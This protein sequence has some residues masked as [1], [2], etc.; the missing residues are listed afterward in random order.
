MTKV[1]FVVPCYNSATSI[2]NVVSEIK[3]TILKREGYD[4]EIILINDCSRDKTL[5][6]IENICKSN[7]KVKGINLTKNFGQHAALM[8]GYKVST[9]DIV[10]SMDDDG[11][12]PANEVFSLIDKLNEGYDVVYASYNTKRHGNFRNFGSK[13]NKIMAE[14]LINKPKELQVTSYF[15]ARR[16]IINEILKYRNAFPYVVGLIL[17]TT[18]NI[19]NTPVAHLERAEGNSNYNLSKLVSLWMNGFTAF[20]VKPLRIASAIGVLCALIG[21]F[22]TIYIIVYKILNP[23]LVAGYSSLMAALLFLG[24]I[25]LMVLGL[26]GE[27]IG[28]IYISLNNSP[29]YVINKTYN[30][31]DKDYYHEK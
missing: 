27:Y 20:S 23:S 25:I 21:F 10:V 16:F 15:A 4:Y 12:T 13:V 18:N 31:E 30:I 22:F 1:S 2:S 28:R 26:I 7:V 11:Q 9:G 24:G 5:Q 19:T 6:E 14:I 29:Q 17:R 8:S 3:K